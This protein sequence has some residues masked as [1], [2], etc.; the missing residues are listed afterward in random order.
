VVG[1]IF[2][3]SGTMGVVVVVGF[4]TGPVGFRGEVGKRFCKVDLQSD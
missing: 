1:D 4:F 2:E 3:L